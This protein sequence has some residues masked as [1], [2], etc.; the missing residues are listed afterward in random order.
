MRRRDVLVA[1][2]AATIGYG[3]YRLIQGSGSGNGWEGPGMRTGTDTAH[4]GSTGQATEPSGS[5]PREATV[6]DPPR[7]GGT[8]NGR[9]R[10]L[11]GHFELVEQSNTSWLHAFIEPLDKLADDVDPG[12]DPDLRALREAVGETGVNLVISLR[13]NFSGY[14]RQREGEHVPEAG[15]TREA[16]LFEY[17]TRQLRAIGEPV[18]FVVLGNEP[19]F[20]TLDEDLGGRD[21]PLIGFTR[22]LREHLRR[23]YAGSRTRFLVGAFNKLYDPGMWSRHVQFYRALFDL[24]RA[25]DDIDGID[26]HLHYSEIGQVKEMLD[27]ARMASPKSLI[28]ATEFSPIW[29]YDKYVDKKLM[30][31]DGGARFAERYGLRE[32]MT[33][34]EYY[35]LAKE[36]PRPR[37]EMADF[38]SA[39][40][41]YNVDLVQDMH[42]LLAAHDASLGAIGF[43]IDEGVRNA[44]WTEDWRPFQINHLFQPPFVE[45]ANGAHPHYMDDY[46]ELA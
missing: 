4:P 9:P 45:G 22:R 13:W 41:W 34:L 3:G 37:Q 15:S 19:V 26:L 7:I 23:H 20:E 24:A 28:T 12:Q 11:Q 30:S 10:R 33:V 29:R 31:F 2:A 16:T 35:Q 5:T 8:L 32:E 40:H 21:S 36:K 46:R 1:G 42:G 25:H 38:M 43:L 17:V 44:T 18:E 27:V 14:H 6:T 39:M